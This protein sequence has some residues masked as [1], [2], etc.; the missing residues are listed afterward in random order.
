VSVRLVQ[1]LLR[2]EFFSRTGEVA[3]SEKKI[4]LMGVNVI[5]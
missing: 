4:V 1:E 3:R 2:R 5:E